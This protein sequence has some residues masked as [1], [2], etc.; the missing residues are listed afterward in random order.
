[1]Q[2][3]P[4]PHKE[5]GNIISPIPT[6]GSISSIRIFISYGKGSETKYEKFSRL[7]KI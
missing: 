3:I 5:F 4:Q 6:A 2:K 7:D 1:M